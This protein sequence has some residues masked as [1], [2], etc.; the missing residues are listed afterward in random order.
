VEAASADLA[1]GM[2]QLA[3]RRLEQFVPSKLDSTDVRG[4]EWHYLWE[5]SRSTTPALVFRGHRRPVYSVAI[6]ADGQ[7]AVSGDKDGVIKVWDVKTGEERKSFAAHDGEV[8]VLRLSP[9][10]RYLASGGCFHFI[11]IWNVADWS[12]VAEFD[13]HDGTVMSVDFDPDGERLISSGRDG[14]IRCWDWRNAKVLWHTKPGDV[15]HRVR[16]ADRGKAVYSVHDN[17]ILTRWDSDSG[18]YVRSDEMGSTTQ[19]LTSMDLPPDSRMVVGGGYDRE[20]RCCDTRE[21]H[22]WSLPVRGTVDSTTYCPDGRHVALGG[23][24]GEIYLLEFGAGTFRACRFRQWPAH[25][26]K[27]TDLRFSPDGKTLLSASADGGV[28]VWNLSDLPSE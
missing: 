10:G 22:Q 6:T 12:R 16:F 13:A 27:V 1:A 2:P 15:V 3:Y 7:L 17:A 23:E 18:K 19:Q 4:P 25:E 28:K 5:Q 11:R 8:R 21:H 14:E 20:I 24:G 26:G 9:D